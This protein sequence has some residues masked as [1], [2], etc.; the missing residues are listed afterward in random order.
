MLLNSKVMKNFMKHTCI[1]L[2]LALFVIPFQV[3]GQDSKPLRLGVAGLSHGHLAEVVRRA[4]RGDFVIVGVAEKDASLR[5]KNNLREKVDKS[6]FYAELEEMLDKTKPE[7]VIVYESIYDH[8]RVVE[9]CAPRG[10]HVMVEKPLA[11]NKKHA[12]KMA[13]LARKHHIHLLTNYETTWY[14]TNHEAHQLIKEGIIGKITRINVY[15]GHQGPFEIGCGKEFTDWL[16]DPTLNGGG[17]VIDFGCYGANLATL[18]LKNEKPL[19]VYGVLKQQ[20]PKTYPKVDD[21]ATIVISYPSATVQIMASWNW[22]MNRK[23]MHIYGSK[24]YIYQDTPTQMRVYTTE[25]KKEESVTPPTLKVPYNDAF[26]Y[27]KAV[28]RNEIQ[29]TP[30]DLSSLENNLTVVSILDAAIQ[31]AKSG[32]VINFSE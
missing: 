1:V 23:D 29:V 8:L 31:S 7:A 16:T 6:L 12:K 11:V 32:K 25:Q 17:A 27:L 19:R 22:P 2:L 20:K 4:N 13:E 26:Y 24:G 14:N 21:D 28:V 18:L 30:G 15:D 10:I 9:A 5:E 3:V